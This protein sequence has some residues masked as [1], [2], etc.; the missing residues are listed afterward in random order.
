MNSTEIFSEAKAKIRVSE[1]ES[2]AE[3]APG[4]IHRLSEMSLV[5]MLIMK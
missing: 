1:G 2:A 3:V 4:R 5:V